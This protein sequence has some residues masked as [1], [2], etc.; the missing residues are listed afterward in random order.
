ME[1]GANDRVGHSTRLICTCPVA[2]IDAM[3]EADL[4]DPR[5]PLHGEDLSHNYLKRIAGQRAED[6]RRYGTPPL[7]KFAHV[8]GGVD[9]TGV[10][11]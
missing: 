4:T 8:W 6:D 5:C 9:K 1:G 11:P 3:G 7:E 2:A 10:R